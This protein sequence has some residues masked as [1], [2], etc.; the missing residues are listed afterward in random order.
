MIMI[1]IWMATQD[2]TNKIHIWKIPHLTNSNILEITLKNITISIIKTMISFLGKL[3]REKTYLEVMKIIRQLNNLIQWI[4][5]SIRKN[6]SISNKMVLTKILRSTRLKKGLETS[7]GRLLKNSLL[8]H[9]FMKTNIT[10]AICKIFKNK[11]SHNY[12]KMI[13]YS[14]ITKLYLIPL[15]KILMTYF[16]KGISLTKIIEAQSQILILQALI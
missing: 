2:K 13:K 12:N 1:L 6:C 16:L 4:W 14:F 5:M 10:K 8:F 15:N 9:Q 11:K 7:K 3:D